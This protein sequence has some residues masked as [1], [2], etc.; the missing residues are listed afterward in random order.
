[1]KRLLSILT[2]VPVCL[3]AM[4]SCN[5]DGPDPEPV[6]APSVA[7]EAG[8]PSATS[9]SFTVTPSDASEAA[10]AVGPAGTDVPSAAAILSEGSP[11]ETGKGKVYVV[12]GLEP[13]TDYTIAAAARSGEAYSEVATAAMTTLPED[14]PE[15]EKPTVELSAGEAA[16]SSLSFT[17]TPSDNADRLAWVCVPADT[18]IPDA[19]GILSAGTQ[20]VPDG[21]ASAAA[22]GLAEQTRYVIGAVGAAGA[23]LSDVATL[24]MVTA[25]GG[26]PEWDVE[27]EVP[28]ADGGYMANTLTGGPNGHYSLN[29]TNCRLDENGQIA[30]GG[31][32]FLFS[33]HSELFD[34]PADAAPAPGTYTIDPQNTYAKFTIDYERSEYVELNNDRMEVDKGK[35][36]SGTL[37]LERAADGVYTVTAL[38]RVRTMNIDKIFKLSY[39]GPVI[40]HDRR[41][42][43]AEDHDLNAVYAAMVYLGRPDNSQEVDEWHLQLYDSSN[44]DDITRIMTVWFLTPKAPDWRHPVLPEGTFALG[45][46][47]DALPWTFFE[48]DDLYGMDFGTFYQFRREDGLVEVQHCN[49]GTF[50][51]TRSGGGYKFECDFTTKQDTRVTARYTG[52]YDLISNTYIGPIDRNLNIAFTAEQP[53]GSYFMNYA[54]NSY[55]VKLVNYEFDI[56][57]NPV[58]HPGSEYGMLDLSLTS[59]APTPPEYYIPAGTYTL[60]DTD[61]PGTASK[62]YVMAYWWDTEGFKHRS[63]FR[64]GTVEVSGS[65]G[66]YDI[67][68]KAETAEGYDYEASFSGPIDLALFLKDSA[69]APYSRR[70][71]VPEPR[72]ERDGLA[73]RLRG[74]R[75][76]R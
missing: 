7:V 22:E 50:A 37:T 39:S 57:L 69:P 66:T 43:P 55:S 16:P 54:G 73:E 75:I 32:Q 53:D 62:K 3:A 41:A 61:G 51:I 63:K 21:P 26:T 13:E 46:S 1:M 76:L 8:E 25:H 9:L 12:S 67:R 2:A 29:L 17:L 19:A 48:G 64:S 5:D 6:P 47:S 65:G 56:D 70:A 18:E 31:L 40:W 60:S 38:V 11:A 71:A 52:P 59:V 23:V 72:S 49:G 34:D 42:K 10:Y 27:L 28:T 15:P 14:T 68:M 45:S 30:S 20:L 33:F 44:P 58:M 36:S 24:E 35:I 74:T 4:L